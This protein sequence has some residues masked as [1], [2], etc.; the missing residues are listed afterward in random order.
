MKN[1]MKKTMGKKHTAEMS[2]MDKKCENGKG[3]EMVKM[4]NK[5]HK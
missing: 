4:M 2:K 5:K 3:P 1:M